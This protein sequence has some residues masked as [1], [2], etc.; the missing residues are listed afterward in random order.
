MHLKVTKSKEQSKILY[1]L[2]YVRRLVFFPFFF[3]ISYKK[4]ESQ[5]EAG[6]SKKTVPLSCASSLGKQPPQTSTALEIQRNPFYGPHLNP[7]GVYRGVQW[8][9]QMIPS[10]M[11]SLDHYI[12][13]TALCMSIHQIPL[14]MLA[15]SQK[16]G[17]LT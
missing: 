5:M 16:E 3:F 2:L 13:F 9:P 12:F 11:A 15:K 6:F 17:Q 7:T 8:K 10:D 14:E 4:K 1:V